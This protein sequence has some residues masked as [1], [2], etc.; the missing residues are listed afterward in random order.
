MMQVDPDVSSNTSSQIR[1]MLAGA[2]IFSSTPHSADLNLH[3]SQKTLNLPRSRRPT[4][5]SSS[6]TPLRPRRPTPLPPLQPV[7]LLIGTSSHST[8]NHHRYRQLPTLSRQPSRR[9]PRV[10]GSHS[11]PLRN[12]STRGAQVGPYVPASADIYPFISDGKRE[13][14]QRRSSRSRPLKRPV[15]VERQPRQPRRR[16]RP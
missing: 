13:Q 2:S 11:R 8:Y 16:L 14:S 1:H 3:H 4:A 10:G 15:A 6:R 5:R 12:S 9:R 7:P